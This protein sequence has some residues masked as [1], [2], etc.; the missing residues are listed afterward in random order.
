[1]CKVNSFLCEE[2]NNFKS[3]IDELYQKSSEQHT[4][5]ETVIFKSFC[6][7]MDKHFSKDNFEAY[8]YA[9]KQYGYLSFSEIE[10]IDINN[11]SNGICSH[12]LDIW[13][14]P[15]GCFEGD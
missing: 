3:F 8:D 1:M 9:R 10:Q 11:E 2:N 6:Y 7:S 13:T 4:T 14:C 12:G 15:A 5:Y